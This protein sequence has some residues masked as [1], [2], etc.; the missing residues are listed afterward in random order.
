[1]AQFIKLTCNQTEWLVDA[2]HI[3]SVVELTGDVLSWNESASFGIVML[4]AE[5]M[6]VYCLQS[7]PRANSGRQMHMLVVTV[8]GEHPFGVCGFD[9]AIAIASPPS[10]VLAKC[11]LLVPVDMIAE[12]RLQ[13]RSEVRSTG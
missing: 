2:E 11:K 8:N 4:A 5:P 3:S 13:Q 12:I 1:M 6:V 7:G 9:E 10:H